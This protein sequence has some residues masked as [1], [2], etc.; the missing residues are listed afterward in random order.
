MALYESTFILRQDIPA[1]EVH[2]IADEF[3]KIATNFNASLIKKEY[4]GLRSLAYIIKKNKKGHYVMLGLSAPTEAI[5]ELE[6]NYRI[7]ENVIKF[8]TIRVENLDDNP[9]PM[10]Q[11]PSDL[12][13]LEEI[14]NA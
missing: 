11:A 4:W 13:S 5:K 14:S 8:A 12:G 1:N 10:M 7:N 3:A 9:S 6:R 2:R